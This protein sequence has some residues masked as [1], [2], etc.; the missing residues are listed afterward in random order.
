MSYNRNFTQKISIPYSGSVSYPASQNG[1]T[2]SYRG[3]A[4]DTLHINIGVDTEPFDESVIQC[5]NTVNSLTTS[6]TA[7]ESAQIASIAYNAKKIGHTIVDGFFNTIRLEIGQ[8]IM[9]L[10]TKIEATLIHLRELSRRCTEKQKQMEKD[11]QNI[12]NRYL[13][14]FEDLNHELSNRIHQLD[15]PAFSFQQQSEQQQNRTIGNDLVSTVSIFGSEGG[16]LQARISTSIAKKKAVDAIE[17]ANFFLLKQK[18]LNESIDKNMLKENIENTRYLPVCFMEANNTEKQ[19]NQKVYSPDL[20]SCI[21]PDK[22]LSN[23]QE[24]K[25]RPSSEEDN[26]QISR[27]FNI[28]LNNHYPNTDTHTL[29]IREYILKMIDLDPIKSL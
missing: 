9:E 21:A 20:L 8:Q 4:T 23:F 3:Y 12:S 1:G 26:S 29:R 27:Y 2:M 25:W 18:E 10:T 13:R 17:K 15:K 16:E 22:F 14:I 11:Y 5:N 28:L 19:I 7:T 6:V 24:K